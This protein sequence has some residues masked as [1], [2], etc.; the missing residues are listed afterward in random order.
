MSKNTE[1]VIMLLNWLYWIVLAIHSSCRII[2]TSWLSRAYGSLVIQKQYKL[3]GLS[4]ASRPWICI[5]IQIRI[6]DWKSQLDKTQTSNTQQTTGTVFLLPELRNWR[7]FAFKYSCRSAP[8]IFCWYAKSCSVKA[9]DKY[10][11]FVALWTLQTQRTNQFSLGKEYNVL[12][13]IKFWFMKIA[14]SW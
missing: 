13:L 5:S 7:L 14:R 4:N 8:G 10:H 9:R 11:Y 6:I 1:L 3:L 2:L 12:C